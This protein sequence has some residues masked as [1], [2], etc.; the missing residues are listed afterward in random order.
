MDSNPIKQAIID[1]P[2]QFLRKTFDRF[3]RIRGNP[4][5][6]AFGFAMGL[7]IGI[8]PTMGIQIWSAVFI[9]AL[10]KWN[11]IAAAAGVWITNPLTAPAIYGMTYLTG[12]K[13]LGFEKLQ[14]FSLELSISNLQA[15]IVK[16]PKVFGAM[17]VGGIAVGIP[18]AVIAYYVTFYLVQH[19]QSR[20]KEKIIRQKTKLSNT[21]TELK[22]R[23]QKK[24]K[25]KKRTI[26]P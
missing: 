10:L 23:L 15:L 13:I 20:V 7:F 8:S 12:A 3:I 5:D 19:Y 1:K 4:R 24:R 14:Q 18:L 22:I 17:I 16:A 11:K 26:K 6:I 25:R 9:A 2:Q 21:K